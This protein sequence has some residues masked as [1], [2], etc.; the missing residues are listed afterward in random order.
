MPSRWPVAGAKH[1]SWPRR[2]YPPTWSGSAWRNGPARPIRRPTRR[3]SPRCWTCRRT[4]STMA[5]RCSLLW[6]TTLR[7]T[8]SPRMPWTMAPA[9]TLAMRTAAPN[10]P[11]WTAW[12]PMPHGH[13]PRRSR[14]PWPPLPTIATPPSRP[15]SRPILRKPS[16]HRLR[17]PRRV[18]S[19]R[20]RMPAAS[21]PHRPSRQQ[22]RSPRARPRRHSPSPADRC[23]HRAMVRTW[24]SWAALPARRAPNVPRPFTFAGS[25][26]STVRRWSSPKPSCAASVTGAC[27]PRATTARKALRCARA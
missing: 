19:P 17:Q 22:L 26:N 9:A 1:A 7:S 20:S 27:P 3:A 23:L 25:P 5:S 11:R 6:A 10:S 24:C 18:A 2:T 21:S 12:R 13:L 4:Q 16:S 14:S 15:T 8:S